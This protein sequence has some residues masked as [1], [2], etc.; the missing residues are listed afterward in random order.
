M[1]KVY[2]KYGHA[3]PCIVY[4]IIYMIW[5]RLIETH[6]LFSYTSIH[7]DIDYL[8]PF[9]EWFIIPYFLWFFYVAWIVV[10]SFFTSKYDYFRV[11]A[12]LTTGMTVFLLVSTFWPNVQHLR[13]CLVPRDNVL[14]RAVRYLYC[15]DT[16][17][18]IWP[19]IHVYNSLGGFF[20]V[21]NSE[22][23]RNNKL[24]KIICLF[25]TVSIILSTVFLKQ[26]SMFDVMTAF[27][28]ATLVYIVVYRMDIIISIR[29]WEKKRRWRKL[30]RI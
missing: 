10:Y 20:A 27:I 16:P 4:F 3:L 21:I 2:R 25:L 11:L 1:K 29:Y 28:M 15:I 19:S 17:T 7:T 9:C 30:H 24:V 14:S 22:K 13:P 6:T 8:I 26:H 18:N 5:F 12:F 23:L